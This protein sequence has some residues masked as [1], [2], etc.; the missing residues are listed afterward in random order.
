MK[1]ISIPALAVLILSLVIAVGSQTFLGACV[2]D[3]GG[4]GPCHWASRAVL[5]LGT[6]QAVMAVMALLW[7]E[8]RQGLF[9]AMLPVSVLGLF[10]P[11]GLI[12]ICRMNTMRCRMVM[13]PAMLVLFA[14]T[15][16]FA[17]AGGLTS[18]GRK[19]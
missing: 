1:K 17:L 11:G 6:A 7:P 4:F 14:L 2:H 9:P 10:T 19:A 5:G 13:R 15:L 18:R 8:R 3:D 12:D 16:A